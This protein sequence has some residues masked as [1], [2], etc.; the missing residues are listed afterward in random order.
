MRLRGDGARR[1]LRDVMAGPPANNRFFAPFITGA[2]ANYIK[3]VEIRSG[4]T[5]HVTRP[6]E[7]NRQA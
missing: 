1:R 6:A 4:H 3:A 5:L 7:R 2:P